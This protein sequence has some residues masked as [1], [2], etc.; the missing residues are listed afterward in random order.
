[1]TKT[2]SSHPACGVRLAVRHKRFED[3]FWKEWDRIESNFERVFYRIDN[4]RSGAVHGQLTDSF[5]A[6]RPM[7]VSQFLEENPNGR[8][9]G[10]SGHNVIRHLAVLHAPILPNHFLIQR[11][12]D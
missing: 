10:G 1:M 5:C 2:R 11:V 7:N 6:K 4:G 3:V 8:K 12:S 9:V